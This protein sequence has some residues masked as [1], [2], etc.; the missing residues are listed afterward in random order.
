[1]NEKNVVEEIF[2]ACEK[3]RPYVGV[4]DRTV[5]MLRKISGVVLAKKDVIVD[6]ALASLLQEEECIAI[7]QR[8]G[9]SVERARSLLLYWLETVFRRDYDRKHCLEVA[10]IALAHVKA[11]VPPLFMVTQMGAFAREILNHLAG[12]AQQSRAVIQALFWNLAVMIQSYEV[13]RLMVFGKATGIGGAVYDRLV[14]L[15]AKEIYDVMAREIEKQ[16]K[17]CQ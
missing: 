14:Q 10:K 15:Y 2:R 4:D 13:I 11:G 6:S 5:E 8:A 7:A 17:S 16:L 9:L 12:D 1:M 3:A